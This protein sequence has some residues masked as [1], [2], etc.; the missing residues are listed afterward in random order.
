PG[1]TETYAE[2]AE[3][4]R[5]M[6]DVFGNRGHVCL[7]QHR[8]PGDA[9]R[10]HSLDAQAEHYGLTPLATGDVLYD[11]PQRRMLQDVVTAI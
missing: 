2:D 5:W 1:L 3:A 8:R 6:A 11:V 9:Q 7:T 4:L 10:L